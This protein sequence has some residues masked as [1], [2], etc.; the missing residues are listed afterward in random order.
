MW[1]VANNL[2]SEKAL[3]ALK[4]QSIRNR[5]GEKS[6]QA[7]QILF[8]ELKNQMDVFCQ[9]VTFFLHSLISQPNLD[10][11]SA[12]GR[13]LMSGATAESTCSWSRNAAAIFPGSW[14]KIL[15]FLNQRI[16][17]YCFRKGICIR[18]PG[19]CR[20]AEIW[21]NGAGPA[22]LHAEYPTEIKDVFFRKYLL[23]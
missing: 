12:R 14:E 8:Q 22:R 15:F 13:R 20:V 23:E 17:P 21:T 9:I 3:A 6:F 2:K 19:V 5:L 7:S 11:V 18:F 10:M 4:I 1:K 16:S